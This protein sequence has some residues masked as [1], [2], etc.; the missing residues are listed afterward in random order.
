MILYGPS[1]EVRLFN[2]YR[3]SGEVVGVDTPVEKEDIK[4]RELRMFME[5]LSPVSPFTTQMQGT[6]RIYSEYR[7]DFKVGD[8]FVEL[9]N[10]GRET[11]FKYTVLHIQMFRPHHVELIMSL[12]S[13]PL[14]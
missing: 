2:I 14:T 6:H 4:F 13:Q 12:T 10:I 3:K 7:T 8:E 11:D 9:D 1:T 5:P